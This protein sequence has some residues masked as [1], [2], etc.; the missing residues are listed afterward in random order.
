MFPAA[1]LLAIHFVTAQSEPPTLEQQLLSESPARLAR[2][3][4]EQ[5]DPVRGAA[6]FY[7]PQLACAKCHEGPT[8]LGPELPRLGAAA[9]DEYLIESVLSPSKSIKKGYETATIS[10]HDGS[11]ASGVLAE[12]RPDRV[13]LRD[14]AN[15][16]RLQTIPRSEIDEISTRGPSMMPP[17]LVNQL[18]GRQ[19][20]LDLVRYLREVADKGPE[21]ARELRPTGPLLTGPPVPEYEKL[22]DHAGLIAALDSGSFKRG[23]A[24]YDRVCANC[25]GTKEKAGSLP[26]SLKFWSGRFKN[27]HD[28]YA[29]YRTLTH[30]FGQM[31]PQSWMVP[32]Q[33]YDVIHYL[34]EAFVR[35][36]NPAQYATVDPSYLRT[37]PKGPSKGPNPVETEPWREMD[38]G[39]SLM[40]TL[41]VG[42]DGSNFAYKGIAVRLDSGSGGI[43]QGHRWA[44]YDHDTLRL[45]AAWEGTGFIDWNSIHFNGRHEIHPRIV[46]DVVVANAAGIGWANP[47]TGSF[48]DPRPLGRERRPYG[49]LPR[50]W[51]R[52]RG[53]YHHE[54][55]VILSY[56]IGAASIL[57]MPG[58]EL[59]QG[60]KD[61]PIFTRTLNVG[62]SDSELLMRVA[63]QSTAVAVVGGDHCQLIE[64]GGDRLLRIPASATPAAVKVLM[65]KGPA[66]GLQSYASRSAALASLDRF[67]RG[68]P[69]RWPEVLT[70]QVQRGSDSGPFAVDVLTHPVANPWRSRLRLTGLDF[71]SGGRQ[72][73]V[74]DWDGDVWLVDGIEDP[75]GTLSWRRI[76]SGL[77][78]P[79]G[80]KVVDEQIYVTCRDQIAILRDYNGDRETDFVECFNDDHQVT[81]HFHEFAMDL[82]RDAQGRF[83]YAKAARHG[84]TAVVPQHGTLLRVS[85]DGTRT[86]ILATGFR[87]PNGVCLNGDGT[88]FMTDQE[89]F[90]L[91][92]NRINWVRE[93]R[94]YGNMWGYHEISDPSDSAMEPPL[95]WITNAFDRSPAQMLWVDSPSWKPLVGSLLSLSYGYGKIFIVPH[96]RMGGAMQG[97]L[98]AL[99]IPQTPTGLIRARFHP[100]DGQLY[101]CGMFAWAGNQEQPGG[102]YRVRYTGKPAYLPIGLN[103]KRKGMAITFSAA[104]DRR[105]ATDPN[106]FAVKTWSLKRSADYGSD[107]YDTRSLG[108]S[109]VT[110]SD[111]GRTLFLE[112]PELKPTWCM[113]I[114]YSLKGAGGEPV[115][116]LIHNTIHALGE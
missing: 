101:T 30:G 53:V 8:P 112:I 39:P 82:Q 95:C 46:G 15:D 92:K 23:E 10:R 21:R 96:E 81:E 80:L 36:N 43:A 69:K 59:D 75:S 12:D 68:G 64:R 33:K 11:V 54:D 32:R 113:E 31:P 85:A 114:K 22:L 25:H 61:A 72:M 66:Q 73:A 4:R 76:A 3:M 84:K 108:V 57:E 56:T 38:Y 48:D 100:A 2:A 71:L 37:L 102:L 109:A 20:F 45:A 104:L 79:L 26:T 78:Q 116:G 55:R 52:F 40:A 6:V 51:A 105:L 16:G 98:C 17:S 29:M 18:A 94:F 50:T 99:P 41:E 34:R 77:F 115:D 19:Q 13:V 74:C 97:G 91:P 86:D 35:P 106:R 93:G 111:D 110:L 49:P 103:A 83:Y 24:I 28:P 90:W 47:V 107:H 88:F 42:D 89:G 7:Q 27:G 65:A 44:V 70:T 63:P 14:P 62:K 58:L 1:L 67:T 5:G 60:A 87:A 9:T